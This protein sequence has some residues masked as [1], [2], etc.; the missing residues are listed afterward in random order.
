M[1]LEGRDVGPVG[2]K[3]AGGQP[4]RFGGVYGPKEPI[5]L[6]RKREEIS[7]LWLTKGQRLGRRLVRSRWN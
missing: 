1:V 5:V 7:G 4:L 6:T 2:T 3:E